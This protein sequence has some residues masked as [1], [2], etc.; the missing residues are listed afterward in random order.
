MLLV[1]QNLQNQQ[2]YK[3]AYIDIYSIY[4]EMSGFFFL[5]FFMIFFQSWT[6]IV[7]FYSASVKRREKKGKKK[8]ILL[9]LLPNLKE[10]NVNVTSR[11]SLKHEC[12]CLEACKKM[13]ESQDIVRRETANFISVDFELKIKGKSL[14]KCVLIRKKQRAQ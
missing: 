4:K 12:V 14:I 1:F 13:F 7:N 9:L 2:T 6:K 10:Q 5:F 3:N 8:S 11:L